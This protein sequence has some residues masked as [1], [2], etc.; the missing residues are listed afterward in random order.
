M[1]RERN[2]PIGVFDSGLGGLTVVR[3]LRA[4]VPNEQIVYLGDTARVPYGTRSPQTVVRYARGCTNVLVER[5]VKALVVACNTACA[6]ALEVLQGEL[7][8]PVIGVIEPG[9][10][11]ALAALTQLG[12][13]DARV[14]V[15]ATRPT[16]ESGAYVRAV[17]FLRP[18][19]VVVQEAAP[20]L[21][22]LAEEGWLSG[23]VPALAV[24]RYLEPLMAGGARVLVLG[25]THYPLLR[26]VIEAEARKLAGSEVLVVDGAAAAASALAAT[27]SAAGTLAEGPGGL[28]L[29]VSD[30]PRSFSAQA[31]RFLGEAVPEPELIDVPVASA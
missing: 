26:Q 7:A 23:E 27:L 16:V 14:G 29:L 21:V 22:P 17:Q 20:L 12:R 28:R 30:L 4:L 11:A 6:V 31:E 25:C 5:G 19:T 18:A 8:I 15:L 13:A 2:A 10:L 24:R 1:S 9:A 3:A